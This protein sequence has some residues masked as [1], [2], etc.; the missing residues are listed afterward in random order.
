MTKR[1]IGGV[2][3]A[4]IAD[5]GA[6]KLEAL[7]DKSR[8]FHPH[9]ILCNPRYGTIHETFDGAS[10][11]P[12]L[13]II[14]ELHLNWDSIVAS[15][16]L[17]EEFLVRYGINLVMTEGAWQDDLRPVHPRHCLPKEALHRQMVRF[18]REGRFDPIAYLYV[19]AE[20]PLD[21]RGIEEKALYERIVHQV[22]AT[23]DP[24]RGPARQLL[25]A[26]KRK[27]ATLER[28]LH[29]GDFQ[30]LDTFEEETVGID[31][32][33]KWLFL[34]QEKGREHMGE[35][36]RDFIE[37]MQ[38]KHFE[39][40]TMW[41]YADVSEKLGC[42]PQELESYCDLLLKG[43]DM[44]F[45]PAKYEYYLAHKEAFRVN[46]WIAFVEDRSKDV[47]GGSK[48]RRDLPNWNNQVIDLVEEFYEICIQ[49]AHAFADRALDH[50]ENSRGNAG[51]LLI[52][53]F[54]THTVTCLLQK[55]G[56]SY[57]VIDPQITAAGEMGVL[58]KA[59]WRQI[60]ERCDF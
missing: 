25:T 20:Y 60:K 14:Q 31:S 42:D 12:L 34:K 6:A 10:H 1:N 29:D 59:I 47:I 45:T 36:W 27:I 2:N 58:D 43:I 54:H 53:G 57:V 44:T 46:E 8:F 23:L 55:R 26:L 48:K 32:D 4:D 11:A 50:I 24:L 7:T 37:Q 56:V 33:W 19:M 40:V 49:R 30:K 13:I 15:G 28:H 35:D 21:I 51:M 3:L 9:E 38:R 16:H 52:G 5:L 41:G 17:V 22:Y 39:H 18:L